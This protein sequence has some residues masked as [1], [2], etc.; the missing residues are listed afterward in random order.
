MTFVN[1][2]VFKKSPNKKKLGLF[3]GIFS[4]V[5]KNIFTIPRLSVEIPMLRESTAEIPVCQS[6][7]Q[8]LHVNGSVY[9]HFSFSLET[10]LKRICHL[11]T[12][13]LLIKNI[14]LSNSLFF[15]TLKKKNM[16]VCVCICIYIFFF[17]LNI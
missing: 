9:S 8:S 17:H 12:L 7:S 6:R 4:F 16:Y 1:N 5:A 11:N 15:R 10:P 2:N 14:L 3:S 13:I